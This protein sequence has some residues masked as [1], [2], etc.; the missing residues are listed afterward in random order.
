[1]NILSVNDLY[2]N[3]KDKVLPLDMQVD[4]LY[5]LMYKVIEEGT[6]K[7][8]IIKFKLQK[9]IDSHDVNR[10]LYAAANKIISN[11]KGIDI[12]PNS[13]NI[14]E[15]LEETSKLLADIVAKRV[16]SKQIEKDVEQYLIEKQD[17]YVDEVRLSIIKKQKRT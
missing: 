15:V 8:R 5:E 13:S 7:S 17:K 3:E 11:G 12:V 2:S 4:V 14:S 1:M 6:I 10:R 16:Y 9:H